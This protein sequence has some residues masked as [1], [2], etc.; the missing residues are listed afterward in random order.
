MVTRCD[1][2]HPND[3][4]LISDYQHLVGERSRRRHCGYNIVSAI[5]LRAHVVEDENQDDWIS[6]R[7]AAAANSID[8]DVPAAVLE[9]LENELRST[10]GERAVPQSER[11][12]I[13]RR[14]IDTMDPGADEE[15][16]A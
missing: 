11:S 8:E 1:S 16:T 13:A 12:D 3:L 4:T 7:V 15:G 5:K 14:L 10:M 9:L 2:E 6:T